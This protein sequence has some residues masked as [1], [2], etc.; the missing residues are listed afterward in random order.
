M[1]RMDEWKGLVEEK[2]FNRYGGWTKKI[3]R[4]LKENDA[5][6]SGGF[7]LQA[8]AKYT[9][10][11]ASDLDIYVPYKNMPTFLNLLATVVKF[12]KFRHFDATLYCRSFLRKNGIRRVHTFLNDEGSIDVMSVRERTSPVAV[13]SNFD[14]TCCQI[15]YDGETVYATHPEHIKE[16]KAYL[17]GDYVRTFIEGN[18]FLKKRIAKYKRRGFTIT[19]DP[20]VAASLPEIDTVLNKA[21]CVPGR[22][23]KEMLPEWFHRMALRY[24]T[25]TQ[26]NFV[27]PLGN[28]KSVHQINQ[29]FVPGDN[30]WM[31]FQ[32]G[33]SSMKRFVVPGDEGYD[34]ETMDEPEL[35]KL[36][37]GSDLQYSR[38]MFRLLEGS[39]R[40]G[41]FNFQSLI[42]SHTKYVK[43]YN[44]FIKDNENNPQQDIVEMRKRRDDIQ[45]Q[46]DRYW[47]YV[48]YLREQVT[49][50]GTDFAYDDGR[51]YDIHL[52]PE[53]AAT[54]RDSL[55]SY[56]SQ[57]I[58]LQDK[59]GGVPCYH[60][61]DAGTPN[62]PTNCQKPI[63]ANEIRA[64]CS[65]D[66]CEK[67]FAPMPLKTG[68]NTVMPVYEA[69]LPNVL[70]MAEGYGMEYSETMC[71]FCLQPVSRNEGCSYMTHEN[72]KRLPSDQAPF[73]QPEFLVKSV[74]DKYKAMG[75]TINSAGGGEPIPLH[76][77]ICVECGRP[78]LGHQHFSLS[79]RVPK[80]VDSAVKQNPNNP[81]QTIF[82]YA[83]CTGGGRA[84]L[85]ARMLAVR[86]VYRKKNFVTPKEEREA[87]AEFADEMAQN[88]NYYA[89][90]KA[91]V[92]M[93]PEERKF[94]LL[95]PTVKKYNDPAYEDVT[96]EAAEEAALLAVN[97]EGEAKVDKMLNEFK[98][99]MQKEDE[100]IVIINDDD[101]E[102]QQPVQWPEDNTKLVHGIVFQEL[103]YAR[104]SRKNPIEYMKAFATKFLNRIGKEPL[105]E[106]LDELDQPILISEQYR[107]WDEGRQAV[108]VPHYYNI[109]W[110][111]VCLEYAKLLFTLANIDTNNA[112]AEELTRWRDA[113]RTIEEDNLMVV[114]GGRRNVRRRRSVRKTLK[115][116]RR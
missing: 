3:I 22:D 89:R 84:E 50:E 40:E 54:T 70:K 32:R 107:E 59:S 28:L 91:I 18:R 55:E 25:S 90:A 64:I 80:L 74:L 101:E 110:A 102:E 46:L 15:W 94:N 37:N 11:G 7:V 97:A 57:F 73:C 82:D 99:R 71:P 38:R 34:S 63:T 21:T 19:Y 62:A 68:L 51:L 72:P 67:F 66:F 93:A 26:E 2:L 81:G 52:H 109:L 1:S 76:I 79:S 56:L 75:T 111:E 31:T 104:A 116:R 41:K 47:V 98:I 13:C 48:D 78:C 53:D 95:V 20:A 30:D 35:K 43:S 92:D 108:V 100:N 83:T 65:W 85:F 16:M 5:L 23:T 86:D 115:H 12:N 45:K 10:D 29:D 58:R 9:F 17:Q 113:V 39:L 44:K 4:M 36:V 77:E 87:A 60:K 49:R 103:Q 27:L 69:A 105:V 106:R 33:F 114:A 24:L 14:L 112:S 42:Q 96:E 61:P 6:L 88:E 8:V